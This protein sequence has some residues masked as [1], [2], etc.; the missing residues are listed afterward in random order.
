MLVVVSTEA[1]AGTAR[2]VVG[3]TCNAANSPRRM[4]R[5]LATRNEVRNDAAG[6]VPHKEWYAAIEKKVQCGSVAAAV[7]AGSPPATGLAYR[8][9]PREEEMA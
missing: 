1:A 6:K 8:V 3:P 7:E 2:E 4:R 5:S 9:R